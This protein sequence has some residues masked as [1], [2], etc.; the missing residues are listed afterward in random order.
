[1]SVPVHPAVEL[2]GRGQLDGGCLAK[3]GA[4]TSGHGR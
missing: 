2:T 1:M 4:G 3:G